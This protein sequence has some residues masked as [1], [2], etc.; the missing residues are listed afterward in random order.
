MIARKGAK[1]V[2]IISGIPLDD[3]LSAS[4]AHT[5][6]IWGISVTVHLTDQ[7]FYARVT[8]VAFVSRSEACPTIDHS[9]VRPIAVAGAQA[10]ARSAQ[11]Q[12]WRRRRQR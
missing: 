2:L 1:I 5:Q 6:L 3:A 7:K 12:R 4:L 9:I 10:E 8:H 11:R